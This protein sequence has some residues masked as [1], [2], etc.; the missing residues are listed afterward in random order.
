MTTQRDN[1]KMRY[2]HVT[3]DRNSLL[4]KGG[5]QEQTIS[6]YSRK[7]KVLEAENQRLREALLAILDD[8]Q[9]DCRK[10][11]AVH[12]RTLLAQVEGKETPSK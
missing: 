8:E 6:D 11:L 12:A 5:A 4:V 1:W 10:S 2:E 9:S 3:K 7:V